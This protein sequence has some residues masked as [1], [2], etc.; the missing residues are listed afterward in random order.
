M[1]GFACAIYTG[2][3]TLALANLIGDIIDNNPELSGLW[4]VSSD[5]I[6]KYDLLGLVNQEFELGVEIER[7][8]IFNSDRSLNS[9][10]FRTATGFKPPAWESMINQLASDVTAYD[11]L[12]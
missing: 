2:F 4:H 7:D 12:V 9:A 3:T 1:R 11:R 8:Q 5:P 6:S 10:R